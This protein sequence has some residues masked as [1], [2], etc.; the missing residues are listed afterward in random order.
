[1]CVCVEINRQRERDKGKGERENEI[2]LRNWLVGLWR[3]ISPKSTGCAI[4]M[5]TQSADTKFKSKS[6]SW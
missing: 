3:L 2:I 4:R 5:D 6:L 1:M